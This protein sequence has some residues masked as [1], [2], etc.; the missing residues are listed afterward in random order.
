MALFV[1]KGWQY[2]VVF[3]CI[4]GVGSGF[5]GLLPVQTGVTFWF[6]KRR[7]LA[8]GIVLSAAGIGAFVAAPVLNKIIS[9]AN[10][11]WKAAWLLVAVMS[12]LA[13]LVVLLFVKNKP[14]DLGQ[15]P[16]GIDEK[17]DPATATAAATPGVGR[18]YRSSENWKVSDALRTVSF[19]LILL[20][21]I[22]FG[23][24]FGTFV[25]HGVIHLRDIGHGSGLAAMS[26]GLMILFSIIGR[27][28]AGTLG[29][30]IESRHIWSV[31]LWFVVAGSVVLV[32][33][34]RV[35][36]VY[37]YAV[38]MGIGFGGAYVC[39]MTTIGNY[40]GTDSFASVMG[41][42]LPIW[43][44]ATAIMPVLAGVFYDFQG[45]YDMS[46]YGLAA[47]ALSGALLVPFAKP[48]K[49]DKI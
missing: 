5:G 13:A 40:F 33:A 28:V 46:F 14:S 12:S 49:P 18:V 47:I 3:G 25:A 7:S 27:L 8:M 39:L 23:G 15:S 43:T 30:R 21:A 22:A 26:V 24:P 11:N 29:D 48:P 16:D 6:K 45:S 2:V 41:T 38:F 42:L 34:D 44:I 17:D 31:S 1:T 35:G 20:S 9:S 4:L 10:G 32:N 36:L 19:W 37:L